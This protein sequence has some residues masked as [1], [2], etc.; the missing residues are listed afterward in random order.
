MPYE[1]TTTLP[2]APDTRKA[3]PTG[4]RK[5]RYILTWALGIAVIVGVLSGLGAT[6]YEHHIQASYSSRLD[7]SSAK[8]SA[9]T[10]ALREADSGDKATADKAL[11]AAQKANLDV[12]SSAPGDFPSSPFWIGTGIVA[13]LFM[14]NRSW[15]PAVYADEAPASA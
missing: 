12:R 5:L 13:F 1:P 15:R 6:Q 8:L 7:A 2:T 11:K 14:I 10:K 4:L 3:R 9:A